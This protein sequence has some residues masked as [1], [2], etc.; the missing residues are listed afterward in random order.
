MLGL[1]RYFSG[2]VAFILKPTA[3]LE[4]FCIWILADNSPVEELEKMTSWAGLIRRMSWLLLMFPWATLLELPRLATL[5]AEGD[6]TMA[7]VTV[8][9]LVSSLESEEESL[10]ELSPGEEFISRDSAAA[11]RLGSSSS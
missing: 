7:K 8:F 1:T 10:S 4:M 9:F 5:S 3:L 11:L 2:E 6:W